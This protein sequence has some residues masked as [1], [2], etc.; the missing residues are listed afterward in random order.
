MDGQRPGGQDPDVLVADFPAVAVRAVQ[1]VDAPSPGQPGNIGELVASPGRDQDPA[2]GHRP[3]LDLDPEQSTITVEGVNVAAEELP[4]VG[5]HLRA[6]RGVKDVGGRAVLGQEV[7]HVPGG[8]VARVAAIDEQDR[9]ARSQQPDRSGQPGR[10][11][12]D[13]HDVIA[14]IGL[15]HN[16]SV[17]PR[18]FI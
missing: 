10:A 13:H 8:R 12:T 7:V 14:V 4:A 9:P 16:C 6:P 17:H 11:A 15:I 1:H 3:A 2:C 5:L 18:R